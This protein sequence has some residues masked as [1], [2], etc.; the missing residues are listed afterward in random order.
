MGEKKVMIAPSI[1]S[2]NFSKL[3]EEVKAIDA[4]GADWVHIDVMDGLFV[5]NITVGPLV[6]AA[7]RPVT[8]LFF[9]VHLMIDNPEKYVDAFID[10]GADMITFHVE[11][12]DNPE[13]IVDK[14]KARGKKTGV[15]IKPGTDVS[16][17]NAV[18]DKIDLV[19]VLSVEPG[20]GGQSF[21]ADQMEKVEN[22][23]NKFS[24]LIQVDGG[25]NAETAR[26]AVSSGV[27]VLVAGTA[28][29]GQNDYSKAIEELRGR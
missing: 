13:A 24:G 28:V 20:F 1:L 6:V 12:C 15:S 2:A 25:I 18:L 11:A 27:D 7:I 22:I 26:I 14:I 21:M 17:L 4:G 29:F 8:E 5:P 10:A 19:L 9:D 3:G 16:S 23:R